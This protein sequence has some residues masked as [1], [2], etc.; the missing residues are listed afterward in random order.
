[1]A[2]GAA[3]SF[4]LQGNA[5]LLPP[6]KNVLPTCKT[7]FT[8]S[9]GVPNQFRGV[10][11]RWVRGLQESKGGGPVILPFCKG[12]ISGNVNTLFCVKFQQ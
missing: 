3:H 5:E 8:R 1:M 10:G 4:Y 9:I 11:V 7:Q 6:F 2:R 12:C